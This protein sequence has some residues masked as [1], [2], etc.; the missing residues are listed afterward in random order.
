MTTLTLDDNLIKKVLD[1]S[2]YQS[3][4]EAVT[5]VLSNYLLQKPMTISSL[6]AMPDAADI[7]FNPPKLNTLL[8][9]AD[10]S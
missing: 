9:P 3:A 10:L 1:K 2:H 8:K 6:L 4:E 7:D 5:Y